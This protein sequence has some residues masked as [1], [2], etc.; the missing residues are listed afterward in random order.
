[1]S[2]TFPLVI[3]AQ[4]AAL[5]RLAPENA[6]AAPGGLASG[7][8]TGARRPSSGGYRALGKRL[9]DMV[10]VLSSLPLVLPLVGLAA[11]ALWIEGG[12]PFYRQDRLGRGGTR[13]S[14]VKLRTMVRDAD[15]RLTELLAR[16]PEKRREWEVSQ[17]LRNDPRVTRVGD[18]LRRTSMDEL[19]QLWN[20]LK[21]EMSLVGPRPMLPEQLPLYGDPHHYFALRPGLTGLWQVGRRNESSFAERTEYDAAYE[22][23]LSLWRDLS[24][25]LKTVGVV[26]R[27]TGC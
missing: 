26:L 23:R 2:D 11:L 20:V 27:R 18:I 9:L 1:M 16:D 22:V 7:D 14:I 8:P 25:M 3:R 4:P 5:P 21:G 13:F 10:L 15:T 12:K 19:P 6:G 24:V 17:K